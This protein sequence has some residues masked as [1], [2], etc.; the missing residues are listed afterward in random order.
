MAIKM[1]VTLISLKFN[2]M[3][4]GVRGRAK[5]YFTSTEFKYFCKLNLIS[6]GTGS[7]CDKRA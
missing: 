2:I 1:F 7:G 4:W 3:L 6:F 5:H